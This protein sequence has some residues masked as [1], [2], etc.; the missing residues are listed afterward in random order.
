M[1]NIRPTIYLDHWALR[2]LSENKALSD[3]FIKANHR[4]N[5]TLAL[6]WLNLEEFVNVTNPAHVVAAEDFIEAILPNIFILQIHPEKVIEYENQVKRRAEE[7]IGWGDISFATSLVLQQKDS[8]N[9]ISAKGLIARV[10]EFAV[11]GHEDVG[12]SFVQGLEITRKQ[13]MADTNLR[14]W[15]E[16]PIDQLKIAPTALLLCELVRTLIKNTT[17]RLIKNDGI[18]FL[19]SVVP[20]SYCDYVLLDGGWATIVEN[21]RARIT[22]AGQIPPRAKIFTGG[23]PALEELISTLEMLPQKTNEL[24]A[25]D[26]T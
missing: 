25:N 21:A 18:D 11:D 10:K 26:G 13:F 4:L 23:I 16:K 17:R 9:P 24:R 22:T 19:H 15:M 8:L 5:G 3:A 12:K 14:K 20:V 2:G 1:K 6:S 7:D